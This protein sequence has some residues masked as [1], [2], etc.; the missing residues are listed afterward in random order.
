MFGTKKNEGTAKKSSS[1]GAAH[2]H[3][4]NSLVQGTLV[5]GTVSS[6]SD[7]RVDGTLEGD[8]H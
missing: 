4:L 6:E 8:L 2:S 1:N 5:K 7:I 3:A